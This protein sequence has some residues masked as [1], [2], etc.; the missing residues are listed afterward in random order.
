MEVV[1]FMRE[2]YCGSIAVE[3]THLSDRYQR[4][5]LKTI[6]E[7][8]HVPAAP[9]LTTAGGAAVKEASSRGGCASPRAPSQRRSAPLAGTSQPLTRQE[10]IEA[11]EMLVRAD[12]LERFLGNKFPASKRFGIEGAE[13]VLPGLH[14]MITAAV[15]R[16]HPTHPIHP[17]HPMHPIHP[18]H[19]P[20]PLQPIRPK[21]PHEHTRLQYALLRQTQHA[22]SPAPSLTAS[23]VGRL[24][25]CSPACLA[26]VHA[27][28][29]RA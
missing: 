20:G 12:H 11:L 4:S 21:S 1:E 14:S 16:T 2:R 7:H 23:H 15:G 29:S 9:S 13:A 5:W 6:F 22:A 3:Y 10:Q 26:P 28:L 27:P 18:I 24:P 19:P 25:A 8:G 17:I